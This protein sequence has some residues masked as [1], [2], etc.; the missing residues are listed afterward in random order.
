PHLVV[1]GRQ[2][3]QPPRALLRAHRRRP[4]ATSRRA[5][6]MA[7][8]LSRGRA[9]SRD[10]VR[11]MPITRP[12]A[13]LLAFVRRLFGLGRARELDARFDRE[14]AFH[15]EMATERNVRMGMTLDDARRAAMLDFAGQS[16]REEWRERSRDEVRSRVVEE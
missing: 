15:V 8:A 7:P 3:Q 14:S 13:R 12:G 16:G 4:L 5:T 9:H 6:G 1:L 11:T 10:G 2:R